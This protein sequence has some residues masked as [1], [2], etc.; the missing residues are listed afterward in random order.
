MQELKVAKTEGEVLMI[1]EVG[2]IR[3]QVQ[4]IQYETGVKQF[5]YDDVSVQRRI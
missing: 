1:L 5:R 4:Y 2:G 3:C